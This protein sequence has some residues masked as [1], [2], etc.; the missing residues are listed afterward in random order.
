MKEVWKDVDGYEGRYQI[1]NKGRLK[2]FAQDQREGKI[3]NGFKTHKGYLSSK[4]YDGNGSSKIYPMHRLVASAFIDN[5]NHLPQVNHKDEDKANNQVDNLEWCTNDY[6]IHYGTK[7]QRSTESN[8][9]CK[10]T[11]KAV[12]SVDNQGNIEEYASIGEA[13]RITGIPH[14]NIV[15][16]LKGRRPSCGN[17]HW[18]YQDD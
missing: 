16:H 6:N 13:E 11:S 14:S 12:Y 3:H 15:R 5:P 1:S 4:L 7:I 18:Y 17:R 9:C 2:S 10:T 8:R